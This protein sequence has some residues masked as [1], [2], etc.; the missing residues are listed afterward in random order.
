MHFSSLMNA[1]TEAKTEVDETT[2][3]NGANTDE[4][5]LSTALQTPL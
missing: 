2:F 1:Q 3:A 5:T 4:P